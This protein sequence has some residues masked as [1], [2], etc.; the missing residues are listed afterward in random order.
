[1]GV[2]GESRASTFRDNHKTRVVYT[3][4]SKEEAK[5]ISDELPTTTSYSKSES[6][7]KLE[8]KTYSKNEAP[9]AL[10]IPDE[11]RLFPSTE[12]IIFFPGYYPAR[13]KRL[14]Y[15]ERKELYSRLQSVSPILAKKR[16]FK[17]NRK[18]YNKA[19]Q[20]GELRIT[21]APLDLPAAPAPK[22]SSWAAQS[23]ATFRPATAAD[24]AT[25]GYRPL[26]EVRVNGKE[27]PALAAM[28]ATPEQKRAHAA[29]LVNAIFGNDDGEDEDTDLIGS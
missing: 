15:F 26:N 1:M 2:Y 16:I 22:A 7:R 29:S 23:G 14:T 3:P 8:R 17:P 24:L 25:L 6:G 12:A 11:V 4:T 28:N 10:L 19:R 13:I 5:L 21:V 9:R 18:D 27:L 20:A